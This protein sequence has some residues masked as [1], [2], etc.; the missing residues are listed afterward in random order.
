MSLLAELQAGFQA[1]VHQGG[2]EFDGAVVG[3]GRA[4]QVTRLDVYYQAY[5]LRLLEVLRKDFPGLHTLLGPEAFENMALDYLTRH[6]PSHPSVRQL[7]KDLE[8]YLTSAHEERPELAEMARFEWT[9]NAAFDAADREPI[10]PA[11]FDGLS[12]EAWATQEFKIHPSVQ[13]LDLRFNVPAIF[14][15]VAREESPPELQGAEEPVAWLV[16]RK[17]LNV[18]WRS[19]EQDETWALDAAASGHNFAQLCEGLCQ[20]H[21]ETEVPLRMAI[22]LKRWVADGLIVKGG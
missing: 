16:W 3:D 17:K 2:H 15:A 10:T 18:H 1:F 11:E 20:W 22:L 5:R 9:W 12:N 14:Q 6:P 21:K 19:L 7:G 13:H 4:D 8:N